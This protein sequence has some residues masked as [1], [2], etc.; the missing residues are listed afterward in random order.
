MDC[1]PVSRCHST[2]CFCPLVSFSPLLSPLPLSLSPSPLPLSTPSPLSPLPLLSL[3]SLSSLSF[4][5]PSLHS[6]SHLSP[7]PL[8]LSFFASPLPLSF[9]PSLYLPQFFFHSLDFDLSFV[10]SSWDNVNDKLLTA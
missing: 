4:P 6:L 1:T 10:A 5:S 7:S 8:L 9:S 3:L 2:R